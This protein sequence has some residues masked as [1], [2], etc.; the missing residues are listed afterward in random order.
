MEVWDTRECV[1]SVEL[2]VLIARWGRME[3]DLLY[4]LDVLMGFPWTMVSVW[5]VAQGT[6]LDV[7]VVCA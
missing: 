3:V 5:K 7:R 2:G 6:A 1:L 4:V